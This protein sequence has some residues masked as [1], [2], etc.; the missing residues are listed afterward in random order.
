MLSNNRL[1]RFSCARRMLRAALLVISVAVGA[2]SLLHGQTVALPTDC[3]V[4]TTTDVCARQL[5]LLVSKRFLQDRDIEKALNGFLRVTQLSPDYAAAW[6]NLAVIAEKT[7]DWPNAEARF[8]RYLAL[9]PK[10]PEAKRAEQ[11]LQTLKPYLTGRV[12]PA[13]A[14]RAEYDASI[15]RA[16][17]LLNSQ[18]YREAVSEASHAQGID[19]SRWE[20]YAVVALVMYKQH[21]DADGHRFADLAIKRSPSD[22]KETLAKVLIPIP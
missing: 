8:E 16:R 21:K 14:M 12:T 15:Q 5:Y 6:F 19:D 7:H 3:N 18:F 2:G 22:K 1:I 4:K 13:E 20:A 11:E 9:A 17:L 10:G